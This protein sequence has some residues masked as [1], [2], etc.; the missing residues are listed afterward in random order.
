MNELFLQD[1]FLLPF[2][3]D[4]LGY[5]EV[6]ANTVS[7]SLI[8]EEDLEAF[9]SSTKL[10]EKPYE[11]LLRKYGGDRKK[12]LSDLIEIIQV[13]SASSRN[14]ALFLSSN[15]NCDFRRGQALSLLRF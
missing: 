14:M 4:T 9:I 12:L 1:K 13:R 10:N 6:R 3:R 7:N 8:I 11:I 15:K 2:F 5:K